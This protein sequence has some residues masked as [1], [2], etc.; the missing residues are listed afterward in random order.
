MLY[1]KL[2]NWQRYGIN[3]KIKAFVLFDYKSP[4]FSGG[5]CLPA[6]SS[7]PLPLLLS[8]CEPKRTKKDSKETSFHSL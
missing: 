5:Y 2:Y 3:F 6:F 7:L 4:G 8:F 1:F